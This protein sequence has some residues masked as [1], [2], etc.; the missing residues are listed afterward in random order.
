MNFLTLICV[1]NLVKFVSTNHSKSLSRDTAKSITRKYY[2][3]VSTVL[4]TLR[5]SN[6]TATMSSKEF[7]VLVLSIFGGLKPDV[8]PECHDGKCECGSKYIAY[9]NVCYGLLDAKCSKPSHCL[10]TSY[11]CVSGTCQNVEH[12]EG[13]ITSSSKPGG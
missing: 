1:S 9:N 2:S 11:S 10:S 6:L 8:F 12:K 13:N 5:V 7:F 4:H 3:N